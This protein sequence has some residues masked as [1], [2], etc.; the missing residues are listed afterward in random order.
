MSRRARAALVALLTLLAAHHLGKGFY[1]LVLQRPASAIADLRNRQVENA[2]FLDRVSPL[3][4]QFLS[5]ESKQWAQGADVHW[6]HGAETAHGALPPWTYPMQLAVVLPAREQVARVYLA[7]LDVVAL[8]LIGWIALLRMKDAGADAT[9]V[10]LV[11]LSPL[12][13]GAI[14]NALTQ[15]Q[16][17]L[18]VNG[19]LA[20]VLAALIGRP[21]WGRSLTAGAA[22]ALA[23]T[24]PSSAVL[25][26]VAIVARRRW[27][28]LGVSAGVLGGATLCAAWWLRHPV[29]FQFEQFERLTRQ[30]VDEGANPFL[31]VLS[32]ATSAATARNALAI[33]GLV[34]ASAMSWTLRRANA[35]V[36]FAGLAVVSRVFTYHRAYDDVLL[37]FLMIDIACRAW[38]PGRAH[39]W[40][41]AW[42]CGGLTVWL[43]YTCY[44]LPS[45]Q[46]IQ[47]VVWCT[48][49]S[50]L[51]AD[52]WCERRESNPHGC[53]P[54]DPKSGASANSATFARGARC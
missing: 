42:L 47:I 25:F 3:S 14:N 12:A 41:V 49:M 22:F 32:A 27:L 7:A 46:L 8:G 18:I 10:A 31:N 44:L 24:K 52:D 11:V 50:V 33:A 37:A 54:P 15:G 29:A 2:Y 48:L 1:F 5:L 38:T 6:T 16:N 39:G 13:I 45:A 26:G 43:P 30:V 28:M 21:A 53:E 4:Q 19:G 51:I 35:F 40:K 23:M 17:S 20:I 9:S 36:L 34:A